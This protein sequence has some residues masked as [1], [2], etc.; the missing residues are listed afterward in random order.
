MQGDSVE[1]RIADNGVGMTPEQLQRLFS[2]DKSN[3][4]SGTAGEKGT[5]LGL[6]ITREFIQINKGTIR[7]ASSIGNGTE[8]FIT[9]PTGQSLSKSVLKVKQIEPLTGAAP[10]FWEA[11]SVDKLIKVRDKKVLIVDHNAELRSYL[12]ML[13]SG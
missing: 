3:I 4:S 10:D 5:G 8:F 11:F 9:L 1:V 13:L 2:L 12:K 6:V 7:V